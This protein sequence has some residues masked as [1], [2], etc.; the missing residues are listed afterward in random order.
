M[1][2]WT[3][4]GVLTAIAL[5]LAL[6]ILVGGGI[7]IAVA[8]VVALIKEKIRERNKKRLDNLFKRGKEDEQEQRE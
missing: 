8:F 2:V 1:F 6:L 4:D 3:F 5:G 7:Y